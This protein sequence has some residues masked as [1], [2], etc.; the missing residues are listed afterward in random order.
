MSLCDFSVSDFMSASPPNL[1]LP[2][3]SGCFSPFPYFICYKMLPLPP[4]LGGI[5]CRF[6]VLSNVKIEMPKLKIRQ[7]H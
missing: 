4:D 3:I 5:I 1:D 7:F 6:Y 2:N